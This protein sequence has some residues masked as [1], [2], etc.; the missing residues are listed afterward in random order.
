LGCHNLAVKET[1][2]AF[3][4]RLCYIKV[5]TDQTAIKPSNKVRR[6]LME[7]YDIRFRLNKYHLARGLA[8]IQ[9]LAPNYQPS[10]IHQ[11]V[12]LIFHDYCAKTSIS[13]TDL[14][15][16]KT[17]NDLYMILPEV[18]GKKNKMDADNILEILDKIKEP[19]LAASTPTSSNKN[20]TKSNVKN[21]KSTNPLLADQE[22]E[23]TITTVQDFSFLKELTGELEDD[24]E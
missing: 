12:K 14:I 16:P 11:L 15:P 5:N 13:H 4:G 9:R 6:V 23:S 19:D 7:S 24:N 20:N 8:S 18:K 3:S 2:V 1:V 22:T 10:S 17:W 21:V